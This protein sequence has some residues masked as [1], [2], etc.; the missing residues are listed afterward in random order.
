MAKYK[1]LSTKKLEPSLVESAQQQDIA[2]TEQ[3]FISIHPIWTKEKEKEVLDIISS[4]KAG[5]VAFTSANAVIPFEKYFHQQD[6]YYVVNWK[7][8]CLSGATK[9]AI[10]LSPLIE[11]NIV[12][13][14]A[15]ATALAEKIIAHGIPELVFFCGDKRREEL[16]S[17]LRKAGITVHEVVVYETIDTPVITTNDTDGILFFSP[18]A[19]RSFFSVNQLKPHTVCFAIGQTTADAIADVTDN[20]IIISEAPSQEMMLASVQFYFKNLNCYE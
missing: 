11:K 5:Y 6:T 17:T 1:I 3:E 10:M 13:T 7:I 8:F 20:R 15:S 16:P 9:D 12:D 19:V 2:I 14:A 4:G 18:S